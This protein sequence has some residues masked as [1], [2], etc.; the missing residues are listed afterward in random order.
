M[1]DGDDVEPVVDLV[2][3]GERGG[4]L[5]TAAG[6][7]E[8]E[9]DEQ[10]HG[11]T[12]ELG[13]PCPHPGNRVDGLDAVGALLAAGEA[14]LDRGEVGGRVGNRRRHDSEPGEVGLLLDG[15]LRPV[16]CPGDGVERREH[17]VEHV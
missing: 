10:R 16:R 3:G 4:E 12:S 11:H 13:D 15:Q 8:V 1:H 6:L 7:G 14:R 9:G 2:G 17:G 5:D